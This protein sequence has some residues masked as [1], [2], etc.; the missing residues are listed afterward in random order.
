MCGGL[1][2]TGP[3]QG[4]DC[5]NTADPQALTPWRYAVAGRAILPGHPG[6][7]RLLIRPIEIT[8]L[9][10]DHPADRVA[11][12]YEHHAIQWDSY[13]RNSPWNDKP[14]HDRFAQ[15]LP[16]GAMVL[17][18]GCGSGDP[19][20]RYLDERG[21]HVTGVDA[22]P[23]MISLCRK[24]LPRQDWMVSDMRALA[25][26]K[27][28][29]GILAWDSYFFLKPDDQQG[30]FNVFTAHA[31]ESA[32]LMFNTGPVGGEAI[33]SYYQGESL[34]HASLDTAVYERL[35]HQHGFDVVAHA[36]EDP[37]ADERT[38]WLA[39]RAASALTGCSAGWRASR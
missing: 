31:D 12:L 10:R 34:Y 21:F 22:S 33:G 29:Q 13:R 20:A 5:W 2:V 11:A 27:R 36:V 26:G 30:M 18:L 14:W 1:K 35:L 7:A 24:R 28:F 25:L 37:Q 4:P 15:A 17:D 23:T 3:P 16:I 32:V 38:V 6:I 9:M 19:V 8:P 39:R